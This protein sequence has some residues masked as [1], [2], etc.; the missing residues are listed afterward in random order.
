MD[1]AAGPRRDVHCP[2]RRVALI[3]MAVVSIALASELSVAMPEAYAASTT[4]FVQL[5]CTN[6]VGTFPD[7]MTLGV[8]LPDSVNRASNIAFDVTSSDFFKIPAP[9][10]G[11]ATFRER[12]SASAGA[13]PSGAFELSTPPTH[14]NIGEDL[15]GVI[16]SLQAQFLASG[17]AGS[18]IDFSFLEFSYTLTPDANPGSTV[19]TTCTPVPAAPVIGSTV[20]VQSTPHVKA[21]CKSG[22]W[23]RLV[24]GRGRPFKNQ[25]QCVSFAEHVH[26]NR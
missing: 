13:A 20:I 8:S 19:T 3:A 21:E 23:R 12:F 25:G 1:V 14:F 15:S 24:N 5:S 7:D 16:A 22:G 26:H 2:Y 4:T 18:T 17:A 6:V 10:S 9:Y 11:T